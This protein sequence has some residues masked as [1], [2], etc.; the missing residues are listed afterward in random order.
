[1]HLEVSRLFT[2]GAIVKLVIRQPVAY[3]VIQREVFDSAQAP[4]HDGHAVMGRG[5]FCITLESA[6]AAGAQLQYRVVQLQDAFGTAVDW[7]PLKLD[8]DPCKALADVPT[9]GWYRLDIRALVNGQVGA[10]A[11]VEPVGVGE[12]FLIAGQSYADNCNDEQLRVGDPHGRVVAY[13]SAAG[14]WRIAHDPQ[15]TP[16]PYRDGG[17]WPVVGDALLAAVR[18]PIGFVN[19]AVGGTASSAWL[20][21]QKNYLNLVRAG[22]AVGSFRYVLWQQGESDVIENV[23]TETY[24]RNLIAIREASAKDWGFEPRWLLAKSTLHPTVY[25]NPSGEQ[26]IR[27]AIDRLW[28]ME[29]FAPGPDTDMLGGDNRGDAGSKRHFSPQGQRA[30]GRMWA[31]C[32]WK[33]CKQYD[34]TGP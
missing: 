21:G 34:Q 1:M 24:I 2:G 17:I 6:V 9:G 19:V 14:S 29:G 8:L 11:A 13:D 4:V 3:Q 16:S 30:A 31:A 26:S 28:T 15:P 33:A 23:P 22:K 12:I 5:S 27:E 7:S 20:P 25:N 10:L 18:A 32:I